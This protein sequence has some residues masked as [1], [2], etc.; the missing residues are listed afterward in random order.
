MKKI[1]NSHIDVIYQSSS[2]KNI[3]VSVLLILFTFGCC[4]YRDFE[5]DGTLFND[6]YLY[7][8]GGYGI[9]IAF[10]VMFTFSS[11]FYVKIAIIDNELIFY[12]LKLL[13][14]VV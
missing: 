12:R 3:I 6:I 13:L 9:L 4:V 1:K 2:L 14:A 5:I 10:L 11:L 8:N 7:R